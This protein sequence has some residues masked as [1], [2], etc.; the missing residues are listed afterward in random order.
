[1]TN[2]RSTRGFIQS[3]KNGDAEEVRSFDTS[4]QCCRGQKSI[5]FVLRVEKLYANM[6]KCVLL[7]GI[8]LGVLVGVSAEFKE[9]DDVLVLTLDTFDSAVE[10]FQYLLA[11]FCKCQAPYCKAA[12][13]VYMMEN[14][15]IGT[16]QNLMPSLNLKSPRT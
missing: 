9:E 14:T 3:N 11:E 13:I 15:T 16:L 1:M 7:I 10:Q 5:V 12:C 2:V 6:A 8:L 4:V